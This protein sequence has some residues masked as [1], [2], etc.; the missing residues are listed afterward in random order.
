MEQKKENPFVWFLALL[1]ILVIVIVAAIACCTIKKAEHKTNQVFDEVQESFISDDNVVAHSSE[2]SLEAGTKRTL[3]TEKSTLIWTAKKKILADWIDVGTVVFQGGEFSVDE[4]GIPLSGHVTVDMDS[5][6][7]TQTGRGD[8]FGMLT[9]H[10]KSADFFDI[11]SYPTADL[12]ITGVSTTK[13]LPPQLVALTADITIKDKTQSVTVPATMEMVDGA[14][15]YTGT[16]TLDRTDFD[17]QFGSETF[18]KNLADNTIID[19]TF[20]VDF[21]VVTQ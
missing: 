10:L 14:Y 5:I 4:N 7:T 17:V 19:D 18:F 11:K 13:S 3:N 21:T 1:P 2:S 20:T 16:L 6:T 9:N 15:I 12:V 8:G